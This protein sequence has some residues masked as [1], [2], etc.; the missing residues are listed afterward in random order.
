MLSVLQELTIPATVAVI[1]VSHIKNTAIP[2]AKTNVPHLVEA[3]AAGVIEVAQ[4]GYSHEHLNQTD[5]GDPTEFFG[6]APTEQTRRIL[7]GCLLIK[8]AFSKQPVGFIP[9]FNTYDATTTSIL[10]NNTFTYLSGSYATPLESPP[11]IRLIPRTSHIAQLRNAYAEARRQRWLNPVIVAIMHHYDFSEARHNPGNIS[12]DKF[13][14][15]L[16]WL[17]QQGDVQFATLESIAQN[18]SLPHSWKIHI[19]H[20]YKNHLSWSIRRYLPLEL[21]Y[22]HPLWMYLRP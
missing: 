21:L 10:Q 16:L 9:P 17:K 4:H 18:L 8:Q 13:K 20:Q 5:A 12:L 1:P 3:Q 19:R 6:V 7:E 2:I 22:T 14:A 11:N 15:D